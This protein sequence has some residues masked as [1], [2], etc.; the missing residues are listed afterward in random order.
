MAALLCLN[1]TN[2][3]VA[4]RLGLSPETVKTHT[5]NLLAKFQL[6]TRAELRRALADWDFSAWE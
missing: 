1:Y 6:R 4:A 2:R 3:Q 5:R